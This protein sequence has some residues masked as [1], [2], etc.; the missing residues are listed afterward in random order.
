MNDAACETCCARAGAS[1]HHS[2]KWDVCPSCLRDHALICDRCGDEGRELR[3]V[4]V[5][6]LLVLEACAGCAD[7]VAGELLS[8]LTPA[9]LARRWETVGR[10]A[11]S[12]ALMNTQARVEH[13]RGLLEAERATRTRVESAVGFLSKRR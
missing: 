13:V 5:G 2:T 4:I 8:R 9:G 1:V 10:V 11:D 7:Q 3:P 6:E 12:H